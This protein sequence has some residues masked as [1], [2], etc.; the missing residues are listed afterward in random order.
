MISWQG[1]TLLIFMLQHQANM[2]SLQRPSLIDVKLQPVTFKNPTK[3]TKQI[4][5]QIGVAPPTNEFRVQASQSV[6]MVAMRPANEVTDAESVLRLHAPEKLQPVKRGPSRAAGAHGLDQTVLVDQR[7][8]R[9]S[10]EPLRPIQS[11]KGTAASDVDREKT[12][13]LMEMNCDKE[14]FL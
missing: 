13:K 4:Q 11:S 1:I 6:S 8:G 10:P 7:M 12:R 9:L 5:K 2:F 3:Q 14:T